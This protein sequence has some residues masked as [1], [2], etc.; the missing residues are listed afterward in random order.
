MKHLFRILFVAALFCCCSGIAK[1]DIDFRMTVL[2][3]PNSCTSDM[4]QCFIHNAGEPFAVA[5]AQGTCPEGLGGDLPTNSY[6]CFIGDNLTGGTINSLTLTF[7]G[8]PLGNQP[9]SCDANGQGNLPSA[10]QVVS[11]TEVNGTY[12]LS[13]AGGAG[14]APFSDIIIF[15]QGTDPAGFQGGEGVVGI[16]PEPD[17]LL[18]FSTGVMMAGLYMSRRMWMTAKGSASRG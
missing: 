16:T 13:F 17:S 11:C 5:L 1:A 6:G 7:E 18:L 10:L 14:I 9:A 8:A 15:E 3:P 12:I 4:T 2:D